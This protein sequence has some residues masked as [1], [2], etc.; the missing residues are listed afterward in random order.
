MNDGTGLAEALLGLD[1]FRVLAVSETPGELTIDIETT[2]DFMGC[3]ACGTRAEAHERMPVEIRD[4]ACFGRPARLVW[5]KRRWRCT[6][7]DCEAKTWT[8]RS[9]QVS[10]RALLTARAGAEACRQVGENARP[11]SELAEE[12][13]VCW[14][15]VMAAVIEHGTPLVDDASRVGAVHQ[16][17]IDET[18]W[19][20]STP[21]HP[22]LYATGLVDLDARILIDMIEGNGPDDLREWCG[23]QDRAWLGGIGVVT[24]DLAESYRSGLE[25]HLAHARRVADPFH[26]VRVGNRCVDKVRRRV[27]NETLGHRGRKRDPLYRI[28][29]LLLTGTE[30]LDQRGRNR[31][32]LGLRVGDPHDEVLG[33]W[34]AKESVQRHLSH[35]RRR[36]GGA[37]DRQGHRRLRRGRGRGDPLARSHP[38][39]LAERDPRA[40]SLWSQQRTD[41]GVEPVCEAGEA[42]RPWFPTV[43]ALPAPRP[44]PRRWRHLAQ[45]AIAATHPDT[46]SLLRRVE[47][48][49]CLDKN[50]L[51]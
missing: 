6:D 44:P 9:T 14:W 8:E 27:Q 35:R 25:P 31:V 33:A 22:T 38:R 21:S 39:R 49:K 43:R 51:A 15:T 5:N 29:K 46:R 3:S 13:G 17:G 28:R 12:L 37:V 32:L 47:P 7:A 1:G 4:L 24:T 16:L 45:A 23:R 36:G 41:R 50:P 2:V 11:V 10:R 40:P 18:A 26:V 34:L 42:L 20:K 48:S 30:R 19:L